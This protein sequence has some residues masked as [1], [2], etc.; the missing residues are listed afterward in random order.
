MPN[1]LADHFRRA[2]VMGLRPALQ[3]LQRRSAVFSESSPQLKVALFAEAKLGG[4]LKRTQTFALTLDK[5]R[6]FASDFVVGTDLQRSARA[7]KS[8][9][10]QIELRQGAFRL[11]LRFRPVWARLWNLAWV[12]DVG[13]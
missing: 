7:H 10:F 3:A 12:F 13:V 11:R 8:L 9:G 6:Q 2:S 5:H 1:H 4:G